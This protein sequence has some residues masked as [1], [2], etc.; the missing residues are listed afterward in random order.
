VSYKE[1]KNA[2]YARF[3]MQKLYEDE[4]YY[5]QIDSHM[6]FVKGWD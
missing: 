1:A 4:E 5:L 2:Y 6:R 3:R